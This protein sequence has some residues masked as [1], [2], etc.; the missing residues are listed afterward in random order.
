M[1]N[2][3]FRKAYNT[4]FL[5]VF[6]CISLTSFAQEARQVGPW[7]LAKLY[8]TP[9]FT[10]TDSAAVEGVKSIFY[11]SL[12]Y[13]GKPTRVY[14]Y[15][16]LPD[17]VPPEGG[18]PA[19]VC[20]HGGGGTAFPEWIKKWNSKGYA[21][22]AMDMDGHIP[23]K[24]KSIER[25]TFEG[26]GPQ[27]IGTF[28][29]WDIPL[30]DQWY[31][32]AVAQTIIAHSFIRSQ[33]EV[34]PD[35]TGLTGISWGGMVTS[36]VSGIDDRFKF[37]IPVYGC[38]Y[39]QGTDGNMG[40]RLAKGGEYLEHALKYWEASVYLP[41]SQTPTLFVNSTNDPFFPLPATVKSGQS[42]QGEANYLIIKGMPHGHKPGWEREE[43]YAFANTILYGKPKLLKPKQPEINEGELKFSLEQIDDLET[44]QV[45]YTH[46][47]TNIW[48]KKQWEVLEMNLEGKTD[49]NIELPKS[50]L[51]AYYHIQNK[52]GLSISSEVLLTDVKN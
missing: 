1:N 11:N 17:G 30:E 6:L 32:H 51:A 12:P 24:K 44:V 18:W 10:Y 16:S 42:I 41:N 7:K 3:V 45:L 35:K 34:N 37:T 49:F 27:K 20:L 31:Y 9:A 4:T 22:I 13:Q 5:M 33:P 14:A 36:S 50:T 15:Y 39:L 26:S 21:A 43:I 25:D 48:A 52:E 8:Q 19:V 46:D 2:K 47:T 23:S 28:E 29:D 38:G 40:R